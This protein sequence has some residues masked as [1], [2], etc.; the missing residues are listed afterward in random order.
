MFCKRIEPKKFWSFAVGA[1]T[2]CHSFV[3]EYFHS[4]FCSKVQGFM[5]K[6]TKH[7]SFSLVNFEP[8]L[9]LVVSQHVFVCI[10]ALQYFK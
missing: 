5:L 8:W 7:K 2:D 1:S 10:Q 9:I 3:S 6:K 4:I